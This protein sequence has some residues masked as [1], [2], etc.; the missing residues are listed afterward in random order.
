VDNPKLPEWALLTA[1]DHD[2]L[3]AADAR[4]RQVLDLTWNAEKSVRAWAKEQGWPAPRFRF[5]EAFLTKMLE[6]DAC[7]VR[8]LREAGVQVRIPKPTHTISEQELHELDAAY[9]GHSWRWLVEAL[10]E[11]RRAVEAGVVV[12]VDGTELRSF[13]GFYDWAHGRYHALE[14]D[15]N[16]GWIGDESRHR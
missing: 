3:A 13:Q 11:V 10:R 15:V 9:A 14:D 8:A 1:G 6:S 5:S 2:R 16:T 12:Y 4:R 7:F